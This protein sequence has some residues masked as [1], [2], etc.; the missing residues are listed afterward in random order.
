M[1][2]AKKQFEVGQRVKYTKGMGERTGTITG[3][4]VATI[5]EDGTGRKIVRAF[6]KLRASGKA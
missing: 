1:A 5:V 2:K 6:G 3:F 4:R